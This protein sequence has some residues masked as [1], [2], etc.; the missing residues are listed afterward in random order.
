ML[1]ANSRYSCCTRRK[2]GLVILARQITPAASF[3]PSTVAAL[4]VPLNST[5]WL[6]HTTPCCVCPDTALVRCA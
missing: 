5:V 4:K 3:D 6:G 2:S 1:L